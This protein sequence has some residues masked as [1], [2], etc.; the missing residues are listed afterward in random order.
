M[1]ISPSAQLP[2]SVIPIFS[3]NN[4]HNRAPSTTAATPAYQTAAPRPHH[5]R[6]MA[7][8]FSLSAVDREKVY[9][10]VIPAVLSANIEHISLLRPVHLFWCIQEKTVAPSPHMLRFWPSPLRQMLKLETTSA[11]RGL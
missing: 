4:I 9:D 6:P 7:T 5:H 10:L 2:N 1:Q 11:A 8:F 3:K